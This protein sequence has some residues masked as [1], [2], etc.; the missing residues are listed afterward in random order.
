MFEGELL[1]LAQR[2]PMRLGVVEQ[3][4]MGVDEARQDRTA[5]QIDPARVSARE[6]QHSDVAADGEDPTSPDRNR[7]CLRLP[8]VHREDDPAVKNKV[9]RGVGTARGAR[10]SYA[11]RDEQRDETGR[12]CSRQHG[13]RILAAHLTAAIEAAIADATKAWP[14]SGLAPFVAPLFPP[15]LAPEQKSPACGAVVSHGP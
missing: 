12:Q 6:A 8:L 10:G 1:R 7:F 15:V 11:E 5:A 14:R 9:G 2:Q 3:V 13:H 4:V